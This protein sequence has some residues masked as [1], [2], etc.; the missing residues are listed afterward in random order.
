[1]KKLTY[2]YCIWDVWVA[3]SKHQSNTITKDEFN[4]NPSEFMT[5][6]SCA[7]CQDITSHSHR[8]TI[9]LEEHETLKSEVTEVLFTLESRRI[10]PESMDML[11]IDRQTSG[12]SIT[13]G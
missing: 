1:V 5:L 2:C 12:Y 10:F 13:T 9:T 4:R 7:Y 11:N 3:L 8:S 6:K